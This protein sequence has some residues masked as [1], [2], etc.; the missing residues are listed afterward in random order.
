MSRFD[1][2]NPEKDAGWAPEP[3]WTFW[4]REK[5]LTLPGFE[6]RTVEPLASRYNDYLSIELKVARYYVCFVVPKSF[7]NAAVNNR[8]LP[9]IYHCRPDPFRDVPCEPLRSE[10]D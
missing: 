5:F 2:F 9:E 7:R 8:K 1:L 10:A 3:V 4:R 6:L